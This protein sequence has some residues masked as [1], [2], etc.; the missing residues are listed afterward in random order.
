M[1]DREAIDLL[2]VALV[3]AESMEEDVGIARHVFNGGEWLLALMELES[4][5]RSNAEYNKKWSSGLQSIRVA[6]GNPPDPW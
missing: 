4:V 1:D 3:A 5:A 2:E 6:L